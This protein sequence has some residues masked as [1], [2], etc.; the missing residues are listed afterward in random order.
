MSSP[1]A[2]II[3]GASV[4]VLIGVW[5]VVAR[6]TR[7]ADERREELWRGWG[8]RRGLQFQATTRPWYRGL[9]GRL[10]GRLGE[11]GRLELRREHRRAG[12]HRR[13]WTSMALSG[14]DRAESRVLVRRRQT[15]EGLSR[16]FGETQVELGDPGLAA[17]CVVVSK[18]AGHARALAG[19][20]RSHLL[21]FPRTFELERLDDRALLSW[22]GNE[23]D[24]A[25]L[26]R[27]LDLLR[28][29]ESTPGVQGTARG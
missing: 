7:A 15:H 9:D 16:F 3:V 8:Q 28:Q 1:H 25:V 13:P 22:R 20:L 10:T 17:L 21:A 23:L 18:D 6:A 5:F 19:A 29:L 24:L 14:I 26:D 4:P 11:R 2:A 12:R 27:A